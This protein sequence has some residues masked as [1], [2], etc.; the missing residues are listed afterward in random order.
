VTENQVLGVL[1]TPETEQQLVPLMANLKTQQ[2]IADRLRP[3]V[4][5]GVVAQQDL[6]RADAAVQQAQSDVDRLRA[7]R[8]FNMIRAPFPG[9]VTRRYVDVGALMPAPSAATQSAAPLVDVADV[10][11][12]RVVVY[13]GQR[14][15]TGIR[16]GDEVEVARDDDRE[17]AVHGSV[18][19]M[20]HEL[21]LRTRTM[22][23]ETDLDNAAL[24]FYPGVYVTVTLHVP[25][26]AGVIVP[27]DAIAL[28]EGKTSVA[29]VA[30]RKVH[31]AQIDVADEDGKTARVTRGV[32]AG[33]WI[34]MRLSDELSDGG[35]AR[36]HAQQQAQA[37]GGGGARDGD[38]EP[39]TGPGPGP[40][41]GSGTGPGTGTG[42]GSGTG[43]GR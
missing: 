24:A 1:T 10:S 43:S 35:P 32:K 16:I 22:W 3:L 7:I 28:V 27:E 40:G 39:G 6:D 19:R 20:P 8:G 38:S 15:A 5:R 18:S 29:V 37:R 26:P 42:T 36:P 4:P 21:D 12:V 14:D 23:V 11:R 13:V 9:V 17:H 33:E 25:A 41:T 2:A 34:A 31:F 30:D